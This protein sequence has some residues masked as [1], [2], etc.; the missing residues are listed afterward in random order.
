M[1]VHSRNYE[2]LKYSLPEEDTENY[3]SRAIIIL[4]EIKTHFPDFYSSFQCPSEVLTLSG[5][6]AFDTY[7][8]LGENIPRKKINDLKSLL[9]IHGVLLLEESFPFGNQE[10]VDNRYS[11]LHT[12]A[13]N[14]IPNRYKKV[15]DLEW[16]QPDFSKLNHD[17][18]FFLWWLTWKSNIL[19]KPKLDKTCTYWAKNSTWMANDLT[20]GI[21]LGYPG[22]AISSDLYYTES[23]EKEHKYLDAKI[24]HAKK[25][26]GAHPV[27]TYHRDLETNANIINHQKLWSNILDSVYA[28]L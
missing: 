18:D 10:Y 13:F 12:D 19:T 28:K 22:E 26:D 5:V 2:Y 16:N 6:R 3:I 7:Y 17:T 15:V 1:K 23:D 25:F 27:Y 8:D 9:K 14:D 20:F 24:K 21:L 4:R 11:I